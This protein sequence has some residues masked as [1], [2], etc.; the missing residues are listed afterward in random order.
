MCWEAPVR[1]P[2]PKND[3]EID[4]RYGPAEDQKQL[5]L[6]RHICVQKNDGC[7]YSAESADAYLSWFA[8]EGHGD[9][10]MVTRL[11]RSGGMCARHT[12]RLMA[13]PG[14]AARLAAVFK[15]IVTAA[16]TGDGYYN[17]DVSEDRQ[18]PRRYLDPKTSPLRAT[19]RAG[20]NEVR[21][22]VVTK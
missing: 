3:W 21:L 20:L 10:D 2:R 1:L 22:D 6:L 7:W 17:G 13:Q 18:L 9:I 14:A 16:K 19:I 11:C 15:Y 8:L 12:R 4:Y 5:S